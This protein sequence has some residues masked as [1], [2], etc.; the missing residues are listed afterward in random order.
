MITWSW[1]WPWAPHAPPVVVH[2]ALKAGEAA[3]QTAYLAGFKD[4]LL[5]AVAVFSVLFVLFRR[6]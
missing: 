6:E 5:V 4:G 2:D 3:L 1:L